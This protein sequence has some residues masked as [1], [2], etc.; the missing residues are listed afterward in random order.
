MNE[1]F[2]TSHA[3]FLKFFTEYVKEKSFFEKY[4]VEISSEYNDNI[5]LKQNIAYGNGD[6]INQVEII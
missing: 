3:A 1:K 5:I 4:K 2:V 6:I